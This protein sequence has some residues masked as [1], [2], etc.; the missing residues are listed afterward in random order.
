MLV[1]ERI[2]TLQ[3]GQ[4]RKFLALYEEH[5]LRMQR[6]YL[7]LM[8]GYYLTEAGPLNQ[9]IHLW[10]HE[11]FEGRLTNREAM[12]ADP[13]FQRYWEMVRPLIVKQET[14]LLVPASFY[15]PVLEK[16]RSVVVR[17]EFQAADDLV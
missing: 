5:G 12:R 10:G 2:Y 8:L 4:G 13:T 11:S 17:E 3:A 1:E 9:V 6:Q 7:K 15:E 16:I 14:K